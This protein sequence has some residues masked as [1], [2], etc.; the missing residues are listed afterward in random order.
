VLEGIQISLGRIE[1]ELKR[2]YGVGEAES[3]ARSAAGN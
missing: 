2:P 3:M 1:E